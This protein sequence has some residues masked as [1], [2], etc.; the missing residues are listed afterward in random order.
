MINFKITHYMY[1][2]QSCME[3][4]VVN[5]KLFIDELGLWALAASRF[6]ATPFVRT[7]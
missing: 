3:V 4:Q 6:A 7:P 2:L 1:F 5:K